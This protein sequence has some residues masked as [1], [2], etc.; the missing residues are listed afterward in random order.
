MLVQLEECFPTDR[1]SRA[2]LRHLLRR[3]HASVWVCEQGNFLAGNSMVLYRRNTSIARL[4]SLVVHPDYLRRGIAQALLTAAESAA[5]ERGY[6]ELRL[7]VRPDNLPAIR[8][9]RKSGYIATGVVRNYYEDG[10]D[11]LRMSKRLRPITVATAGRSRQRQCPA[12][13][14]A[15]T[16]V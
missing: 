4:Y 5:G 3:G 13:A 15:C 9:Y 7:E 16:I 14:T 12:H 6:Q 10:M 1:L 11:A 8:L 2:N